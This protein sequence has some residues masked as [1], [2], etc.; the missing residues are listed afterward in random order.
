MDQKAKVTAMGPGPRRTK[1]WERRRAEI[2]AVAEVVFAER[3]LAG[4]PLEEVAD[5]TDMER[6]SLSFLT[7][8]IP[9][10]PRFSHEHDPTQVVVFSRP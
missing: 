9:P 4:V 5:R 6:P 8:L 1:R 2:L 10:R 7:T 3:G